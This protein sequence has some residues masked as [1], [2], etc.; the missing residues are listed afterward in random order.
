MVENNINK[1]RMYQ[2]THLEALDCLAT[3]AEKLHDS[4]TNHNLIIKNIN[5]QA[6]STSYANSLFPPSALKNKTAS[7]NSQNMP[8][9]N[10][11]DTYSPGV[12]IKTTKE[13][14]RPLN[15]FY[16]NT[17]YKD[18]LD[19]SYTSPSQSPPK[20]SVH[21][22]GKQPPNISQ[23]NSLS[24]SNMLDMYHSLS[25]EPNRS[26]FDI[27]SPRESDSL[28]SPNSES[29][30]GSGRNCLRKPVITSSTVVNMP[31]EQPPMLFRID[32]PT[33]KKSSLFETLVQES[34]KIL[35][36]QEEEDKMKLDTSKLFEAQETLLALDK[37]S[38]QNENTSMKRNED[39]KKKPHEIVLISPQKKP[40]KRRKVK[41]S[42]NPLSDTK[43][44]HGGPP[45]NPGFTP[46]K[47]NTQA[48]ALCTLYEHTLL[49][50][51]TRGFWSGDRGP[52]QDV[53][54]LAR[55]ENSDLQ[56]TMNDITEHCYNV[57]KRKLKDAGTEQESMHKHMRSYVDEFDRYIYVTVCSVIECYIY[58]I[59][60]MMT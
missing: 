20:T 45:F 29:S 56:Y 37:S 49:K 42:I 22:S 60:K 16:M 41:N 14:M 10:N 58:I 48:S 25:S 53:F 6:I 52:L 34:H 51:A 11:S 27:V 40:M 32:P 59:I 23:M 2:T 3:T 4:E 35:S 12:I 39:S 55:V 26:A 30:L 5:T 44:A 38:A 18:L 13:D 33:S 17:S 28:S 47:R 54:R 43:R 8:M 31:P 9:I 50:M 46:P 19:N 21:L 24:I 7:F 15:S 36:T 57:V 1:Y